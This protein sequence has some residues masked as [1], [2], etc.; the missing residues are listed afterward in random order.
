M[1]GD[2]VTAAARIVPGAWW[3]CTTPAAAGHGS[4]MRRRG[5]TGSRGR[6]HRRRR[7]LRDLLVMDVTCSR[8]C[9]R[10]SCSGP[11]GIR[12]A[13]APAPAAGRRGVALDAVCCW[14]PW[15]CRQQERWRL[16][17]GR[18]CSRWSG[19]RSGS[20]GSIWSILDWAGP[21]ASC[22]GLLLLE[23]LCS[24]RRPDVAAGV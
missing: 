8:G 17:G 9:A 15:W 1:G 2:A 23:H 4:A 12:R 6:A 10:Q 20:V 3:R 21:P 13:A 11:D 7:W 5:V 19:Q 18:G 24:R 22:V 16:G 14:A